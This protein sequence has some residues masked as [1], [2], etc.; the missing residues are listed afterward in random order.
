MDYNEILNKFINGTVSDEE[1]PTALQQL[2]ES[3]NTYSDDLKTLVD[4][5]E[6]L[7]KET[8]DLTM[9][10]SKFFRQ[11]SSGN[12]NTLQPKPKEKTFSESIT[13]EDLEKL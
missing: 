5:N 6:K 13:I 8:N 4:G 11:L 2:R 12:E 7:I 10:N 9:S 3:F 1:R